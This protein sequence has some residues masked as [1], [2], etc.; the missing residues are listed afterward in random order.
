MQIHEL[1]GY[2]GDPETTDVLPIDTGTH[3]FKLP[4]AELGEA[5]ITTVSATISGVSQTVKAAIEALAGRVSTLEGKTEGLSRS[6]TT[7]VIGGSNVQTPDGNFF[8]G[9]DTRT[10]TPGFRAK[11]TVRDGQFECRTEG[12]LGIFDYTN[13]AWVLQSASDQTVDVPHK[14]T[15]RNSAAPTTV[16]EP[17]QSYAENAYMINRM[18]TPSESG[19]GVY[20]RWG[21]ANAAVSGKTISAS[22]SDRRLKENIKPAEKSGIDLINALDVVQFDWKD[23]HGHWDFGI[24]A[25]DAGEIDK[26]IPVGKEAED[27]FITVDTLYLVDVLIK[28]VQELSAEVEALKNER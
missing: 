25:Q 14:F 24:I 28:A 9:T 6:G 13:N 27:M 26:N 23:G 4:F 15:F 8:S 22:P 18:G 17:I 11:N 12:S 10:G 2:S 16:G 5:I 7:L 21:V 19:V 20:A 1:P 3:T